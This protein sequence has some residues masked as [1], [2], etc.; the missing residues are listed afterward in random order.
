VLRGLTALGEQGLDHEGCSAQQAPAFVGR[1]FPLIAV[2]LC[3]LPL[4]FRTTG[5]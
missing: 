3:Q 1:G 2:R 5:K 4:A